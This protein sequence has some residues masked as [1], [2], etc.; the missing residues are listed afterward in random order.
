MSV[1]GQTMGVSVYTDP[2]L[3]SLGVNRVGLSMAYMFGTF[4]SALLLPFVGRL[5]DSLG[6]RVVAVIASFGLAL[7]LLLL[8]ATPFL[9]RIVV[10]FTHWPAQWAGSLVAFVGFFGIRHFG[11]GE[12]TIAS[13]T[14]MA[15]WFDRRR[16]LMLGISGFFV[17]FAFGVAPLVLNRLIVRFTWQRSLWILSAASCVT[18]VFAWIS[19]RKSPE[20]CG[21]VIDGGSA[22]QK[23]SAASLVDEYSYTAS[24][25]KRTVTFWAF[26]LGLAAHALLFTAITFHM[27]RIA[28]L[29]RM[30]NAKAFSVFLPLALVSTSAELLG[31]ALSDRIPLKYLLAFMQ[32][33]ICCG[34]FGLHFYGATAG[35]ALTAAGFG[36]SN[37]LFSLL[38]AAGWPKLFGRE[39]LGAISGVNMSWIVAGSAVGPYLFSLGESMTNNYQAVIYC[40]LAIP[41]GVFL[42]SLFANPPQRRRALADPELMTSRER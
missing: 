31:G 17:A 42:C 4:G 35:F 21:L 24:Q 23:L 34:L 38:T 39:H 12:L 18:A 10:S 6:S 36:I 1:P 26:N 40:S 3:K 11:Q 15:R 9:A 41:A 5:L 20:A 30:S 25:A 37:G 29:N 8:S 28:Q 2:L 13:R 27:E 22:S 7:W 16:G 19:F 33:G 14:M 32:L